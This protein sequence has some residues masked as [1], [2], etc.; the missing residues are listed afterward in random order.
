[1]LGEL[2]HRKLGINGPQR[3]DDERSYFT[4]NSDPEFKYSNEMNTLEKVVMRPFRYLFEPEKRKVQSIKAMMRGGIP[5]VTAIKR[6]Y[7]EGILSDEQVASVES[8][9]AEL[10]VAEGADPE[11]GP[12]TGA[13]P[14]T[15]CVPNADLIPR[16]IEEEDLSQEKRKQIERKIELLLGGK[17]KL[18]TMED[19]PRLREK[20]QEDLKQKPLKVRRE[21][22]YMVESLPKLPEDLQRCLHRRCYELET[23]ESISEIGHPREQNTLILEKALS[24]PTNVVVDYYTLEDVKGSTEVE[25]LLS[26]QAL[27]P[28]YQHVRKESDYAREQEIPC[29]M[30]YRVPNATQIAS[31]CLRE[32]D[33]SSFG[34]GAQSYKVVKIHDESWVKEKGYVD[35]NGIPKTTGFES[36]VKTEVKKKFKEELA[37]VRKY[38]TEKGVS[39]V[40][41]CSTGVL[42]AI[43]L[44]EAAVQETSYRKLPHHTALRAFVLENRLQ[45]LG[46][47]KI[48]RIAQMERQ[49]LAMQEFNEMGLARLLRN[50]VVPQKF[51]KI[52]GQLRNMCLREGFPTGLILQEQAKQ[53]AT[54]ATAEEVIELSIRLQADDPYARRYMRGARIRVK[55]GGGGHVAIHPRQATMIDCAYHQDQ[56]FVQAV[57]VADKE[58]FGMA[59]G[60]KHV[61]RRFKFPKKMA[62]AKKIMED[63]IQEVGEEPSRL[64]GEASRKARYVKKW[65]EKELGA[66]DDIDAA[67]EEFREFL[68]KEESAHPT[69][70]DI[71]SFLLLMAMMG[72]LGQTIIFDKGLEN[73]NVKVLTILE[74][75][76]RDVMAIFN[77]KSGAALVERSILTIK[78]LLDSF[79]GD[80]ELKKLPFSQLAMLA[81]SARNERITSRCAFESDG[82]YGKKESMFNLE[83]DALLTLTEQDVNTTGLRPEHFTRARE[84]VAEVAV[85]ESY[86]KELKRIRTRLLRQMDKLPYKAGDR[87]QFI[88]KSG[89]WKGAIFV[90]ALTSE[91]VAITNRAGNHRVSVMK[92]LVRR[93]VDTSSFADLQSCRPVYAEDLR[94]AEAE[95][96]VGVKKLEEKIQAKV[97]QEIKEEA[98]VGVN[99]LQMSCC[100][101]LR[102][103]EDS[104]S[105]K[106]AKYQNQ[107]T[108]AMVGA[109]CSEMDDKTAEML[110][111][112]VPRRSLA[113]LKAAQK[114][115]VYGGRIA[116]IFV[117]TGIK[118]KNSEEAKRKWQQL[119]PDHVLVSRPTKYGNPF[120]VKKEGREKSVMLYAEKLAKQSKAEL[121]QIG[122]ELKNKRLGCCCAPK[123]CHAEILAELVDVVAAGNLE[124]F[125]QKYQRQG[126]V[127]AVQGEEH[128]DYV[129]SKLLKDQELPKE[130][131]EVLK[132]TTR[133]WAS[134]D[135]IYRRVEKLLDRPEKLKEIQL[136][137][138]GPVIKPCKTSDGCE[139]RYLQLHGGKIKEVQANS[140]RQG[141]VIVLRFKTSTSADMVEDQSIGILKY[142]RDGRSDEMSAKLEAAQKL[143]EISPGFL[144]NEI[145]AAIAAAYALRKE[146]NGAV[147]TTQ[148][149]GSTVCSIL[150][151][152]EEDD[153]SLYDPST[154]AT[155][156]RLIFDLK[157][158]K[159]I[160]HHKGFVEVKARTV[161]D[162]GQHEL[163][164]LS[165]G[166]CPVVSGEELRIMLAQSDAILIPGET[167]EV[168][169]STTDVPRAFNK[170]FT[171]PRH[172][173][174]RF[175]GPKLFGIT[176]LDAVLQEMNY[177]REFVLVINIDL[178]GSR[179]GSVSW[180]RTSQHA[181]GIM[182][183]TL[184]PVTP[185]CYVLMSD[186][187]F[188]E[189]AEIVAMAM[190]ALGLRWRVLAV[191]VLADPVATVK[192]LFECKVAALLETIMEE[193]DEEEPEEKSSGEED[194]EVQPE[195]SM[196]R[197]SR[198]ASKFQYPHAMQ[199]MWGNVYRRKT[200]DLDT[201]MVLEDVNVKGKS[202]E[203][204]TSRL[205]RRSMN[206]EAEFF[207]NAI[208]VEMLGN[209]KLG[210]AD[211]K[212]AQEL[213]ED[214]YRRVC[215]EI[216]NPENVAIACSD[217]AGKSEAEI[218]STPQ[219]WKRLHKLSGAKLG[220]DC[221]G[222]KH[223]ENCNAE[224]LAAMVNERAKTEL[225]RVGLDV[226]IMAVGQRKKTPPQLAKQG[227]AMR[228]VQRLKEKLLENTSQ[229]IAMIASHV[230]DFILITSKSILAV[231]IKI[232][233]AKEFGLTKITVIGKEQVVFTGIEIVH[234]AEK[235]QHRLTMQDKA[236]ALQLFQD[237]ERLSKPSEKLSNRELTTHRSMRTA[238]GLITQKVRP[239]LA[240]WQR[241][242]CVGSDQG[243]TIQ[244]LVD[245]N[246]LSREVKAS[247]EQGITLR[248]GIAGP[249][250]I[251]L[252]DASFQGLQMFHNIMEQAKAKVQ[253]TDD[254]KKKMRPVLGMRLMIVSGSEW[255]EAM[256]KQLKD[257][258]E[259]D[260]IEKELAIAA[261]LIHEDILLSEEVSEASYAGEAQSAAYYTSMNTMTKRK[262]AEITGR[263]L[264]LEGLLDNQGL[265][266]RCL[267][268]TSLRVSDSKSFRSLMVLQFY[269]A[270]RELFVG[271]LSDRLNT[272]D[273]MTKRMSKDKQRLFLGLMAGL[274]TVCATGNRKGILSMCRSRFLS[275]ETEL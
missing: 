47:G 167:E 28:T 198:D 196:K 264:R 238:I 115:G 14:A 199:E 125:I 226:Q 86:L 202:T 20:F 81:N 256:D 35:A 246:K 140:M 232:M 150:S 146:I 34:F 114:G 274:F 112:K 129:G 177:H 178:Y 237:K 169:P 211:K 142:P 221:S 191:E 141:N 215:F 84:H 219:L 113:M 50:T 260:G 207:C 95:S 183:F 63:L 123:L 59:L 189:K 156:S 254:L 117:E 126:S 77:N 149:S 233:L 9:P 249:V 45:M 151:K 42:T 236:K 88:D 262:I 74:R 119:S 26:F 164:H 108:C 54:N 116:N 71:V 62:K 268:K 228:E 128:V 39:V 147:Y 76:N 49:T 174:L 259:A 134:H 83:E 224:M 197:I 160:A 137:T 255:E 124:Q 104:P 188:W 79:S 131:E 223:K 82:K 218:K 206:I 229:R 240:L 36:N 214:H 225:K 110:Y 66:Q 121:K 239:D 186:P 162:G 52:Y 195:K 55:D 5:L 102:V 161:P 98:R 130:I 30:R 181:L 220:C 273:G 136:Q 103:L 4:A 248:Y 171:V 271:F 31:G 185:A 245:L 80:G 12:S 43:A 1:M 261:A 235:K 253:S 168:E 250:L 19:M 175:R 33:Q 106:K 53:I 10:E 172:E 222:Q 143:V 7:E 192:K 158:K 101:A 200:T 138:V 90:E 107:L 269:I 153:E 205:P 70:N 212:Y 159:R 166:S 127:G 3:P 64:E 22:H 242:C 180:Y 38:L 85:S 201:G 40:A 173:R 68:S 51:E 216:E 145:G 57:N 275:W 209:R 148:A 8:F 252:T 184:S 187:A 230:D 231:I 25:Q 135:K 247:P 154:P 78:Q 21:I 11:A 266:K 23:L 41:L 91:R 29:A 100:G 258:H 94:D 234:D 105:V 44:A 251:Q 144:V 203:E 267:S 152:A 133:P 208:E 93:D 118:P 92:E 16:E 2:G 120:L 190:D 165:S 241:S 217:F 56:A 65:I 122:T 61:P 109:A 37:R 272:S 111:G 193:P 13:A 15:Q 18:A 96:D 176:V 139:S 58:G 27:V 87:V 210:E 182:G 60:P 157:L 265:I 132:A 97:N 24:K 75:L 48:L 179:T 89:N 46:N 194:P 213:G 72:K 244:D 67:V 270:L 69:G 32:Q 17:V 155:V 170:S 163:P 6:V 204:L 257:I 73:T 243:R 99:Y 263:N 227:E